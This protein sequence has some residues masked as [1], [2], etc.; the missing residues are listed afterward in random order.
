MQNKRYFFI[1]FTIV[2]TFGLTFVLSEILLR[3]SK[4]YNTYSENSQGNFEFEWGYERPTQ[5]YNFEPNDTFEMDIGEASFEYQTN[6]FGF[7]ERELNLVDSTRKKVFVF[8]DSF[9]EGNGA[10]YDSSWVRKLESNL[11]LED[12]AY[13]LYVCGISGFD[14]FYAYKYLENDLLEYK[15]S[16]VIVSIND[17]DINEFFFRGGFSRFKDDGTTKYQPPPKFISAYKYSHLV[18]AFVHEFL[19]YD[20]YLIDKSNYEVDVLNALDSIKYCLS[21]INSLCKEKNIPFLAIAHPVPHQICNT[22]DSYI[23]DFDA[24]GSFPF[25]NMSEPLI[26]AFLE[27]DDC[28][29]YH[30]KQ[31]SHF[32]AKGYQLYGDLLFKE[33][34]TKYPKFF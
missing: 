28:T 22:Q 13:D 9:V 33:I 16:H 26:E 2:F 17:S 6:S 27:V 23:Y 3:I 5:L 7:R 31:D 18:R 11:N 21:Q 1:F 14:P 12:S 30:W 20:Y 15:P 10:N 34:K 8:G 19:D 24:N 29:V 4:R 32:N 25:I